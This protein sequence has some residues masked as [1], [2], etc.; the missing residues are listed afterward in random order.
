MDANVDRVRSI[1]D[2][3]MELS[4]KVRRFLQKSIRYLSF[5]PPHENQ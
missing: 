5:L 4:Q 1:L 2:Y 3:E